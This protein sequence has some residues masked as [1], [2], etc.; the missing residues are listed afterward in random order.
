[1]RRSP[2]PMVLPGQASMIARQYEVSSGA[3]PLNRPERNCA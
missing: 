2:T 1:L 3:R